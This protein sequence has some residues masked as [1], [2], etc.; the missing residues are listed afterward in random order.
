[1]LSI[2]MLIFRGIWA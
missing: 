1:M 2:I